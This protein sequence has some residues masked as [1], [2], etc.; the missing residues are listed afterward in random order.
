VGLRGQTASGSAVAY[1]P[2]TSPA[3]DRPGPSADLIRPRVRVY[4]DKT[5]RLRSA[6]AGQ[7]LIEVRLP[8]TR[9]N[10]SPPRVSRDAA[11]TI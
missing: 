3:V 8:F 2:P 11:G 4:V 1:G 5:A 9:P 7:E 10:A 6:E